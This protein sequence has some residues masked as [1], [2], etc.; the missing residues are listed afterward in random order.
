MR[1]YRTTPTRSVFTF[2]N[3]LL[4][5]R[6][7]SWRAAGVR[8]YL[9]G[10]PPGARASIRSL[11]DQCKEGRTRI[12]EALRELEESR[13]LRRSVVKGRESGQLSTVY[14]AFDHPYTNGG[15][16]AVGNAGAEDGVNGRNLASG[17]E[18][19]GVSGPLPP[20]GAACRACA[21]PPLNAAAPRS[22]RP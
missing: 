19:A 3:A 10:L 21:P 22:A 1:I 7:I 15:S 17:A 5:D 13:Y 20:P 14:E 11:A 4:H 8:M 9:L 6:G 2:T 16:G 18:V 12:A